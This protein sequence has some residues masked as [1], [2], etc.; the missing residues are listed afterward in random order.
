M[1]SNT[2]TTLVYVRLLGEGTVVYR[3]TS[4][5]PIGPDTVRLLTPDGYDP[6]D[7]DWEFKPGS[8]V[9]V[10]RRTLEGEEVYVAVHGVG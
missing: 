6:M 5:A 10:E 1:A 3:P 8:V 4:A 9:R 7:E 2:D